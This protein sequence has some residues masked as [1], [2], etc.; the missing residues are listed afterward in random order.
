[1]P[2]SIRNID[3]YV[4]DNSG[5]LEYMTEIAQP[6]K[7]TD[8]SPPGEAAT[9]PS[10]SLR[11]QET[12]SS[13]AQASR[14]SSRS[15]QQRDRAVSKSSR[16]GSMSKNKQPTTQ[17]SNE[18]LT[19][20]TISSDAK[21]SQN[22]NPQGRKHL[23]S[24]S[25]SSASSVSKPRAA[26]PPSANPPPL[27]IHKDNKPTLTQ[28][29]AVG[30]ATQ[31]DALQKLGAI[32]EARRGLLRQLSALDEEEK[33]LLSK[34]MEMTIQP[35]TGLADAVHDM[36]EPAD[37]ATQSSVLAKAP[38]LPIPIAKTPS[39]QPKRKGRKAEPIPRPRSAPAVQTPS[40][41]LTRTPSA[42]KRVPLSDKTEASIAT[43]DS[44]PLYVGEEWEASTP[45]SE[46]PTPEAKAAASNPHTSS[47]KVK[48][49]DSSSLVVDGTTADKKATL[50]AKKG[51]IVPYTVERKKWVF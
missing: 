24:K 44:T 18:R 33:K 7:E 4:L 2:H 6:G 40:I 9:S 8:L 21:A 10:T 41:T 29:T 42:A 11:S 37:H 23:R 49:G 45:G 1:M 12:A 50:A 17:K 43:F 35:R 30:T 15:S 13:S 28:D 14:S 26:L 34:L 5:L 38:V 20:K 48:F 16:S 51:Y 25:D 3:E 39:M 47:V 46:T 27:T 19:T 32:H 22:A 36:R 31:L